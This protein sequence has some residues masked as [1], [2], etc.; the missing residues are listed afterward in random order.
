MS[1]CQWHR[2][3]EVWI[4]FIKVV[5]FLVVGLLFADPFSE[6]RDEVPEKFQY[7]AVFGR[8]SGGEGR[9]PWPLGTEGEFIKRL[10]ISLV[11]GKKKLPTE[12][13]K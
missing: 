3:I 10:G 4:V 11:F 7:D 8:G 12:L 1:R 2:L 6:I 9:P 5:C 13:V